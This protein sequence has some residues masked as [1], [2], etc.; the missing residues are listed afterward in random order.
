MVGPHQYDWCHHKQGKCGHRDMHREKRQEAAIDKPRR[1]TKE[2][3]P[4]RPGELIL[5]TP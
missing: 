4:L 2:S 5:L 3:L 1:E